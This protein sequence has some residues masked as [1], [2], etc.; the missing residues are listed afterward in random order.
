MESG[1]PCSQD[2]SSD[3]L[4][5]FR[6]RRLAHARAMI[7]V[8]VRHLRRAT[9]VKEYLPITVYFRA[10]EGVPPAQTLDPGGLGLGMGLIDG[11]TAHDP[12]NVFATR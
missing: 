4:A 5:M 10:R 3:T 12:R 1:V 2:V 7:G 6:R 11:S 8:S 9:G